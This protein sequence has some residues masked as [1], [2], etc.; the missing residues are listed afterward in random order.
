MT[1]QAML[2]KPVIKTHNISRKKPP[3]ATFLS[4]FP[5]S[6]YLD[7]FRRAENE[8]QNKIKISPSQ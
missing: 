8:L 7:P 6:R 4:Q 5:V 1:A 3:L 2:K